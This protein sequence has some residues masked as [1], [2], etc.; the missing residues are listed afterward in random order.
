MKEIRNKNVKSVFGGIGIAAL[1]C[2][3]MVLMSWSAMVTNSDINSESAIEADSQDTKIDNMDKVDVETEDTS[4]EA[5]NFGFDEDREMLGMRTENTK[6]YLDDNGKQQVVI[7]NKPLHYTNNLGQFVDLDT[8]IKT[9]DNGYYVQDIFNPVAFGNNA[10]EG[11]TMALEDSEIISG[12]DPVPV[13]VMEG[14]SAELQLPGI[15]GA[16]VNVINE[17]DMNYFTPPTENVEVG[18]SSIMYPLA[19]GMDLVYH[20]TPNKVKQEMIIEELSLELKLH[21]QDSTVAA[22]EDDTSTSMFGL[23]ESMILPENTELWAGNQK[24]TA[25]D[26]VFAYNSLLTIRDIDSGA[27]VAYID[28]PEAKDSSSNQKVDETT[29]VTVKPNVQYFIQMAE[30]GQSL[31]IVTAVN[32]EWLLD[33]YTVF[34]VLIDP[35]VGSNTET[36]LTTPGSYNVCVVEDVDCFTRSDGRYEHDYSSS[37][38]EFA[39]WFDFAFTQG[40]ALSVS[41]VTA[42]VTWIN[43]IWTQ[44]GGEFTSIQIME[45]C[46]GSLPDGSESNLNSFAN[47]TGCTG[48]A[49]QAYTPPPPPTGGAT[50]YTFKD[51][52]YNANFRWHTDCAANGYIYDLTSD[53]TGCSGYTY[54]WVGVGNSGSASGPEESG[55]IFTSGDYSYTIFDTSGDYLDGSAEIHFETRAVGSTGAWTTSKTETGYIGNGKSGTIT[56]NN[57]DELRL[58]YHCPGSSNSCYAQENYM[59]ITPVV[60]PPSIPAAA[61]G[62]GGAAPTG[63]EPADVSFSVVSGDEAY[64]EFTTGSAVGDAEE[65]EIYYRVAG[66]SGWT[67]KWDICSGTDCAPN[68]QYF[69]Y[70]ANPSV[71]FQIPGSYE[72]LVWDTFGDGSGTGSGGAVVFASAGS[73]TGTIQNTPSG[74]RLVS[75]VSSEQIATFQL[76]SYSATDRAVPLCS[77]VVD[78]NTG[79]MAMF[80]DAYQ[81]T[82]YLEFTLGWPSAANNPSWS[83]SIYMDGGAYFQDFYLVVELE[84]NTPDA[85]P[86]SVEYDAHYDGV[87][88]YVDGER[89]LFLSLMD[90]N[91]PIDTTTANGPKLHYSTDGGNSYT[92]ASATST[93][94]CNSKNQVCGFSAT[95]SDLSAGTTVDYYWTYSDAAAND[96]SKIPPQTPNPGR[97]PAAG[98]ADLSFTIADVYSAPTD[99]TDMKIVTYMDHIRSAEPHTGVSGNTFA[100]DLDR[101][102]TYYTSSGEFHFEFDLSRCG[103]NFPTQSRVPGTD[104]QGNCFF[105]IDSFTSFGEQAGHW[106]INWEGTANDC[107]PGMTGCT[108]TPTNN[109]ELDAYAGGPLG[110]SGLIGA[111]NLVFV[112]DSNSNQWMISGTGSGDIANPLDVSM[113]DVN[114]MSTFT[115][116]IFTPT[117]PSPVTTQISRES[118]HMVT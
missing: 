22:N 15:R 36:T 96:N 107:S 110:V 80:V 101:Q 76:N 27:V 77:S 60:I 57:G 35:S 105:D 58:A 54:D 53:M 66:T 111:G 118:L 112:Y 44:S 115:S 87:T 30:D 1:L 59:T 108:G 116:N 34:P 49:L 70:N 89:T 52:T 19:Q 117:G 113:P 25:L 48:T 21:L 65:T 42:Y 56:V 81:N 51:Y 33:E 78:C 4:F 50:T 114:S 79:A 67:D 7:S 43:R 64:F 68:T 103:A 46:G 94:T 40:T 104:G 14:Q 45:D 98:A 84:D 99:G 47:P 3:L 55:G 29:E 41:Q 28:A 88:S 63:S 72:I 13:I 6:T 73:T 17:I 24:V 16:Q 102:M 97:F 5:E 9:W 83:G 37:L 82:G 75:L 85:T 26:G 109:L 11:F 32:T 23:M 2:V 39:P 74:S 38:H 12:L 100:S 31:N 91:N 69:S 20:V 90:T 10:Y 62:V 92:V 61:A 71:L 8:S 93:G 86:P 106:D 18:G 95:T